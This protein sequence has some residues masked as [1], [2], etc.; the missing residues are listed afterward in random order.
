MDH[1]S[2]EDSCEQAL[3]SV[4]SGALAFGEAFGTLWPFCVSFAQRSRALR[5][6]RANEDDVREV[7]VKTLE[8]LGQDSA[9]AIRTVPDWLARNPGKSASDWLRVVVANAARDYVRARAGARPADPEE[10]LNLKARLNVCVLSLSEDDGSA[11]PPYTAIQTAR[12]VI[13]F[14]SGHLPADQARALSLW[15]TGAGFDEMA[16]EL[17]LESGEEARKLMRSAVAS[18]RREFVK[19]G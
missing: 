8:R 7:A 16:D 17:E 9:R 10:G 14:A 3:R 11:R 2:L 5:G 18:L 6:I 15:L 1:R 19:A 4:A 13:E 12:Q